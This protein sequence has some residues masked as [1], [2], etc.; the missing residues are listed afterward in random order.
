[1]PQSF[2]FP[3]DVTEMWVPIAFKQSQ[4]TYKNVFLRMYA[5]LATDV[6][7][8]QPSARMDQSGQQSSRNYSDAR[9][10]IA[11]GWRMF[12]TPIARDDDGSLRRWVT[13]LFAAVMC[14]LLIVCSNVAGLLLVRSSE[15]QFELSVRLA[16]GAS[17]FRIA[18]QLLTEV[19]MLSIGGGVVGLLLAR[20]AIS[21]LAMALV[22]LLA[23]LNG[24]QL[25]P[26]LPNQDKYLFLRAFLKSATLRSDKGQRSKPSHDG[27]LFVCLEVQQPF[28]WFW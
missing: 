1:M 24:F 7:F 14:L 19:L 16:L 21:W 13:I 6:T 3:N 10:S 18:R 20:A 2:A 17:G 4:L 8:D 26:N 11:T 27:Q 25:T 23:G 5:R 15:R 22:E 9:R 28:R 12:V